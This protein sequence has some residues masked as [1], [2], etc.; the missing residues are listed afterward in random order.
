MH[1]NGCLTYIEAISLERH[2]R[3]AKQSKRCA[4]I[5][6]LRAT[7]FT[8]EDRSTPKHAVMIFMIIERRWPSR[9][10]SPFPL[11]RECTYVLNWN[12]YVLR[13]VDNTLDLLQSCTKPTCAHMRSLPIYLS[14][15]TSSFSFHMIKEVSEQGQPGRPHLP[16]MSA[17]CPP[18]QRMQS[19]PSC[20]IAV[21]QACEKYHSIY[22][23]WN[24]DIS[25][26]IPYHALYLRFWL[27]AWMKRRNLKSVVP[28]F[29]TLNVRIGKCEQITV[30]GNDTVVLLLEDTFAMPTV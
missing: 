6:M 23:A 24:N 9:K 20:C 19:N 30:F 10:T 1:C 14:V 27:S 13:W 22:R 26:I 17:F 11:F 28:T 5:N 4:L 29:G 12:K 2:H 8:A 21:I 16:L 3:A 18:T 25:I 15:W 7:N